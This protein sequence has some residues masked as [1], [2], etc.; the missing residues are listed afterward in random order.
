L[1]SKIYH[2]LES[3]GKEYASKDFTLDC[4]QKIADSAQRED[5][6]DSRVSESL[7]STSAALNTTSDVSS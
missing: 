1:Y 3:K 6:T 5:K 2:I 7:S 4:I